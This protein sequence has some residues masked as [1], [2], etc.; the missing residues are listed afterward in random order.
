MRSEKLLNLIEE[1]EKCFQSKK[2][3]KSIKIF[4]LI[5]DLAFSVQYTSKTEID[6]KL[7]YF[8]NK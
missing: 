1:S 4:S 8:L 6:V 2:N 3:E 5:K 7:F